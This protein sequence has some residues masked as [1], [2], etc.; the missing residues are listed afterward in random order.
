MQA[1]TNDCPVSHV[2]YQSMSCAMVVDENKVNSKNNYSLVYIIDDALVGLV[3]FVQ[4]TK[5][6]KTPME[7]YYF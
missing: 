5:T 6:R 3:L 7:E 2:T 1:C 4:F